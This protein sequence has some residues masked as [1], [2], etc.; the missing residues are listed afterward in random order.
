MSP[1]RHYFDEP[2]VRIDLTRGHFPKICPIC[3][4]RGTKLA[5]ITIV[6]GRKQYLRRSWDPYYDPLVRRRQGPSDPKL[7]ILPIYMCDN[8][9]FSDEG[10]ERYKTLCI[11]VDGF[12]MAFLFFGLIFIGDSI[13]RQRS[14]SIW[15]TIFIV[16][17]AMSMLFSWVAFRPNIIERAVRIIG[18]DS[19][20]QNVILEFS[21]KDYRDAVIDANPLTSELVSWIVR[22]GD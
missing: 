3:G 19:G 4:E 11:I 1:K 10:Q 16:F 8:H 13:A 12:A 5:R 17:F 15:S 6:S 22:P 21:N 20:M 7:K 14:I 2:V 18:F 9:F